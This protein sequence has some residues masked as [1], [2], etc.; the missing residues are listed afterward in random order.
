[1]VFQK[2]S[3]SGFK[4]FDSRRFCCHQKNIRQSAVSNGSAH[5]NIHEDSDGLDA[6][7]VTEANEVSSVLPEINMQNL[8]GIE[9]LTKLRGTPQ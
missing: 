3:G 6:L 2:D 7:K 5:Q 4:C 9:I 8:D 1:V